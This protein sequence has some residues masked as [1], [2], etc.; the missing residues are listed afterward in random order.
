MILYYNNP[1]TQC[2]AS[3]CP[4]LHVYTFVCLGYV[5]VGYFTFLFVHVFRCTLHACVLWFVCSGVVPVAYAGIYILK[6]YRKVGNV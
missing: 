6:I 1:P 2:W 5:W 4:L 3:R